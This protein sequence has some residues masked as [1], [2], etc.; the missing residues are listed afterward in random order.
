[1]G[2]LQDGEFCCPCHLS[3]KIPSHQFSWCPAA[4]EVIPSS[5]LC[6]LLTDADEYSSNDTANLI[7]KSLS[8]V[9][10]FLAFVYL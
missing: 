8:I 1:M 5:S 3:K 9:K 2:L 7:S 6:V 10:E 4:G